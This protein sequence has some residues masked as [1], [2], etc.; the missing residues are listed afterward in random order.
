MAP[1]TLAYAPPSRNRTLWRRH[2][3]VWFVPVMWLPGAWGSTIYHGDEYFAFGMAN[4]PSFLVLFPFMKLV[5]HHLSG[6]RSFVVVVGAGFLMWLAVGW[7][8]DLL[9]AWRWPWLLAPVVFVLIV[10]SRVAVPGHVPPLA[11]Y[12][13]Q[14]WERDA[15]C[16]AACWTVYA[17]AVALLVGALTGAMARIVRR[18][19]AGVAGRSAR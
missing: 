5:Q 6:E 4:A 16:V 17:V 18:W 11:D 1:D 9:R 8:L 12:P 2:F 3:H 14:E 7:L 13:G 15:V 19:L 10:R